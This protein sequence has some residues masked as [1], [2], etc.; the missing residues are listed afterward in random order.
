MN[1]FYDPKQ[2]E[3]DDDYPRRGPE[4]GRQGPPGERQGM[5][6]VRMPQQ[7]PIVAYTILA[8]TVGVFILQLVTTSVLGVDLPLQLGAKVNPSI[9]QGE[10]WRLF[11]PMLLHGSLA[12]IGFNMYALFILGPG[13]ER[14]YGHLRFLTLY[15]LAGFA[16]NVFSFLLTPGPSVGASTAIFGLVAAQG[17]FLFRHRHLF[18]AGASRG[19][20]NIIFIVAINLFLGMSPGIDNWGHLGGLFGGLA[21]AWLGGPLLELVGAPPSIELEDRRSL[22]EAWLAA[23]VIGLLFAGAVFFVIF[24]Q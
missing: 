14:F 5:V 11:T 21:F 24:M 4:Y 2:E 22:G 15:L 17:V 1:Q 8:L 12:H 9:I 23:L 20:M 6:Q 13:L 19:L 3:E 10:L 18:G 7:R 16:G